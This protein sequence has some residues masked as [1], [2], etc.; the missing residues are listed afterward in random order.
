MVQ[1]KKGRKNLN[2]VGTVI[3]RFAFF[4]KIL[5]RNLPKPQ[6]ARQVPPQRSYM[7]LAGLWST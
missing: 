5:R 1:P 6:A 3:P 7:A 2:S 4:K